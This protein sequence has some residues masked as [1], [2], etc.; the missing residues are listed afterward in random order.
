MM[1]S[2]IFILLQVFLACALPAL[3][4]DVEVRGAVRG[5]GRYD[6]DKSTVVI[7]GRVDVEMDVGPLTVGGAYRAYDFGEGGYNPRGIDPVY[8]IKHR[9]VEGRVGGL[10]FRGGHYFS[11]FGRGLT[12]RSFEDMGLEHDT[13]LDGFIAEYETGRFA[14]VGL[15]GQVAERVTDVRRRVYR[16]RGGRAEVFLEPGVSVA[17]NG[18]SRDTRREDEEVVLPRRLSDF[19][20]HVIGGE[21]GVMLGPVSVAGEYARRNGAYYPELEQGNPGGHG[22]YLTG[23][24]STSWSTLLAEF[25]DYERFEHALVNPPTCVRD[26]VWILMNRVTHQVDLGNERGFLAEGT[27]MPTGDFQLTGGASEARR[28]AGGLAHWEIFGQLD[29]G[30]PVWGVSSVAGSWSREYV[31]GRFTE[32]ATGALDLAYEVGALETVE[33]G[34]EAQRTEEPSGET[35]ETYLTSIALYPTPEITCSL[36]AEATS[37]EGLDRDIWLFGDIRATISGDFEV[38][39]GGGTERGGKKCT[40]GICFTE[41]EFTGIRLRF[42]SYF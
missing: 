24:A 23:T 27:L 2:R 6:T 3:A 1:T 35:F 9:Y 31:M 37:Q 36:V 42:L 30:L 25:K 4:A 8:D 19:A 14:F 16:V 41:P 40:G 39:L 38:S 7:D 5:D 15:G 33:I 10:S 12:L 20:D 13:S 21:V 34:L 22:V 18:V 17:I 26:H 29:S 11:T 32:Y 28:Q